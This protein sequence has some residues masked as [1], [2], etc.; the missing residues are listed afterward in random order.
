MSERNTLA[1]HET[2]DL[3]ELVAYN[4]IGLMKIK[5]GLPKI[6]DKQLRGIYQKSIS[7]LEMS[8]REL[9]EFYPFAPKPGNSNEYRADDGFYAGDLLAFK[10]T[11]VR[12][13][14]VAIT[15]TAT[16][17]LRKVLKKQINQA[18]DGHAEIFN[19]MHSKSMYPSYDLSDILQN[20]VNL[21]NKALS[22]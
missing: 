14:S 1:W 17:Q 9:L 3:H 11:A 21:A 12:N 22:M 2:L 4:S 6:N 20:D 13:Y 5:M 7:E 19:Y 15:E 8:L 16:P 10:K 18:I